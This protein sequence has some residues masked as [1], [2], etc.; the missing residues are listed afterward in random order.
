[1]RFSLL[2][3]QIR[4]SS[5]GDVNVFQWNR[6]WF[7]S[8][9]VI[10]F[11]SG[12]NVMAVHE[13]SR[14]GP[15]IINCFTDIRKRVLRLWR[16]RPFW[17]SKKIPLTFSSNWTIPYQCGCSKF[18]ISSRKFDSSICGRKINSPSSW[19]NT[20]SFALSLFLS[21]FPMRPSSPKPQGVQP[22]CHPSK[23]NPRTKRIQVTIQV[24]LSFQID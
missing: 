6:E 12:F 7:L 18:L 5:S 13:A 15:E 19:G 20:T 3:I 11:D 16:M 4:M 21:R 24:R 8:R 10:R 2:D 22:L 17:F 1:M 9:R 23:F 14:H